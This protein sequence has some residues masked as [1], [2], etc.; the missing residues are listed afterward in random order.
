L[1]EGLSTP[2]VTFA[3][4]RARRG[5]SR[6]Q[7]RELRWLAQ[8]R[9]CDSGLAFIDRCHPYGC[10]QP[11]MPRIVWPINDGET[12]R[13]ENRKQSAVLRA[14]SSRRC[15][16]KSVRGRFRYRCQV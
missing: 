8:V 12:C 11:G 6:E 4:R 3:A 9:P 16:L 13:H 2:P 1:G 14:R 10:V 5:A 7:R 15:C